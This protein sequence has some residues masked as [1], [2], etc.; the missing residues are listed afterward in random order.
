MQ[1]IVISP[2]WFLLVRVRAITRKL[3]RRHTGNLLAAFQRLQRQRQSQALH[4]GARQKVERRQLKLQ[5]ERFKLNVRNEK[6]K[7]WCRLPREAVQSL[8]LE[9][10]SKSWWDK[11]LSNLAWSESWPCFENRIGLQTS[12][13]RLHSSTLNYPVILW[14][15]GFLCGGFFAVYYLMLSNN[16]YS[17]EYSV[18]Y[19]SISDRT[20]SG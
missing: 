18:L 1:F 12:W 7:Q 2:S 19:L 3:K 16:V 4:G 6:I 11:A 9:V 14:S 20:Y 10:P 17:H 13:H 8:P 5:H 15:A